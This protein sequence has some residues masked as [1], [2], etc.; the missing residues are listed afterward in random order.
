VKY[1]RQGKA[2]SVLLKDHGLQQKALSVWPDDPAQRRLTWNVSALS[3]HGPTQGVVSDWCTGKTRIPN[4][5]GQRKN[6]VGGVCRLVLAILVD[7]EVADWASSWSGLGQ[8]SFL[9]GGSS[10]PWL[11]QWVR[12]I[13]DGTAVPPWPPET[14]P[15][16]AQPHLGG[17]RAQLDALGTKLT[18]KLSALKVLHGLN[19]L[20]PYQCD[21]KPELELAR[22]L[23]RLLT[24]LSDPVREVVADIFDAPVGPKEL[25]DV[26]SSGLSFDTISFSISA[27]HETLALDAA[28]QSDACKVC[29]GLLGLLAPA[30]VP[31]EALSGRVVRT[32]DSASGEAAVA[33]IDGRDFEGGI[34]EAGAFSAPHSVRLTATTGFDGFAS[35]ALSAVQVRWGY[36][37]EADTVEKLE[38][39][40][41]TFRVKQAAFRRT[42]KKIYQTPPPPFFEVED[43]HGAFTSPGSF[44]DSVPGARL[45]LL[46]GDCHPE[47]TQI[48]RWLVPLLRSLNQ[49]GCQ[50]HVNE[51]ETS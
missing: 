5:E 51:E 22:L 50:C 9:T 26:L 8:A 21:E 4:Q 23:R 43:E 35:D 28:L 27:L 44:I 16:P 48:S 41:G 24:D 13:A 25:A 31:S 30:A 34:D 19:P 38:L 12:A 49:Q 17:L 1:P 20:P 39:R 32:P 15:E 33:K 40:E 10:R 18:P 36:E 7:R 47:L 42:G 46:G 6:S 45:V 2:L 3:V 11:A 29:C 37:S 14:S